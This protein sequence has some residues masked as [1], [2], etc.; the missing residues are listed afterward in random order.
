MGD[1]IPIIH[2]CILIQELYFDFLKKLVFTPLRCYGLS[3]VVYWYLLVRLWCVKLFV[4]KGLI[5]VETAV[6]KKV[7]TWDK[8]NKNDKKI[9]IE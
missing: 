4:S 5:Q 3:V 7:S 6:S 9:I 8:C 2:V 1:D